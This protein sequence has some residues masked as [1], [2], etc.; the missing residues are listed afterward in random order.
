MERRKI[1]KSGNTSFTLA[2][3]IDWIR[4]NRLERGNLVDVTEN[5]IGDIV[6]SPEHKEELP[7]QK[8]ILTIK[9]NGEDS[10]RFYFEI[11]NA[12]FR[13]YQTIILEGKEIGRISETINTQIRLF[14]GL[15]IIEQTKNSI[16]I[17]NFSSEDQE[18]SPRPLI[19]KMDLSIRELFILLFHFF[20]AGFSKDDFFELQKVR[21]QNERIYFL[22]RKVILR[23]MENPS[24]MKKYQTA[25]H[26]LSKDK[27][28]AGILN[29]LSSL[30]SAM[31][32]SFLY[33][34]QTK[35]EMS[36]LKK[37]LESLEEEYRLILNSMKYKN[38]PDIFHIITKHNKTVVEIESHRKEFQSSAAL[39]VFTYIQV[40][41]ML[42]HQ[43]A[44]EVIE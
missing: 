22:T 18:L 37:I 11:M 15:D 24:L 23:G 41:K 7:P 40:I 3:P 42:L 19:K 9:I 12:Y 25:Y 8:K 35:K 2:L 6:L 36:S 16:V 29:N 21:E 1:V 27:V 44:F 17:K 34:E 32:K 20:D 31:G 10:D 38:Y 33:L 30:L 13:D 28:L 39:E 26:Q 14:I 4:K 5:E 43:L